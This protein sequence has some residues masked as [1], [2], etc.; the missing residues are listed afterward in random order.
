M[1]YLHMQFHPYTYIQTKV[2]EQKL[3]ISSR[4]ITLS[5]Y[6]RTMTKFKLDVYNLLMYPYT[7][8]ELN[9]CN[10]CREKD[11]TTDQDNTICTLHFYG[12]G[13]KITAKYNA[14]W[15]MLT[16]IPL[17]TPNSWKGLIGINYLFPGRTKKGL[18]EKKTFKELEMETIYIYLN[19]QC[20]WP[21]TFWPQ[22]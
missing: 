9:V 8:F 11:G 22:T 20:A 14:L 3:K 16:K 17:L 4:G 12:W 1:T 2:K 15:A 18:E 6:Y 21:L 19:D 7:K 10:C 5:K 13:I